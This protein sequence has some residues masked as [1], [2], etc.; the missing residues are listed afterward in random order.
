MGPRHGKPLVGNGDIHL[1][2]QLGTTFSLVD[3]AP[4]PDAICAGIKAGRVE[5]RSRPL[6]MLRAATHLTR[7]AIVGLVGR[8]ERLLGRR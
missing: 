2:A 5:V 8:A 4:D 7:M 3:A 1:L 6:S